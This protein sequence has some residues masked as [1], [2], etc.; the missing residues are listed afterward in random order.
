V[1]DHVHMLIEIPLTFGVL[2]RLT[3]NQNELLPMDG[4]QFCMAT[5]VWCFRCE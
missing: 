3:G 1:E 2:R 5:R 4:T